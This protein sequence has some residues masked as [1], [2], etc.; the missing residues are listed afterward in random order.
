MKRVEPSEPTPT[1][2]TIGELF[3][4]A[5]NV[6][7]KCWQPFLIM[8]VIVGGL[9]LFIWI[10][11]YISSLMSFFL[12]GPIIAQPPDVNIGVIIATV[13]IL[14]TAA[15]VVSLVIVWI[16]S[17]QIAYSLAIV[18]GEQPSVSVLFSG[19]KNFWGILITGANIA[20]IFLCALLVILIVT[21]VPLI[22]YLE[23]VPEPDP[24]F[25][26][27]AF[28]C[29]AV[30]F[31]ATAISAIWVGMMFC[32]SYFFVVDRQQ[33]PVEAM[34]SSYRY[35]RT[36]FWKVCGTFFL[37]FACTLV[38]SQI[39]LIGFVLTVPVSMCLYT[40]LYLKITGQKHGL[41]P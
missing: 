30:G 8:G 19:T 25:L 9:N 32:L 35:V 17:G 18:R 33:G 21:W 27:L 3:Q 29:M 5:W 10:G 28:L 4:D 1:P 16:Y 37:I 24:V 12:L 34:K 26:V 22:L 36:Y 14:L 20:V 40:V 39:P 38:C 2:F 7:S 23:F 13:A 31:G 6:G 11:T 15:L 41:S